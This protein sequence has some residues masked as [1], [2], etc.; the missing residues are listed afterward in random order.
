MNNFIV[1]SSKVKRYAAWFWMIV[2]LFILMN[3]PAP[4]TTSISGYS[5]LDALRELITARWMK[6]AFVI[7]YTAAF[8]WM[9][10]QI[11]AHLPEKHRWLR[12][13][14]W[15]VIITCLCRWLYTW[16]V[17]VPD[18]QSAHFRTYQTIQSL[19]ITLYIVSLLWT[20]Y[21][22]IRNYGG[23]LRLLGWAILAWQLVPTFLPVLLYFLLSQFD[24]ISYLWL[25]EWP[26]AIYTFWRMRQVFIPNWEGNGQLT[27]ENGQ[28]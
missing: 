18:F 25:I 4:R 27:I 17:P 3:I 23:R 16:L 1:S 10:W 20:G 12:W 11:A 5:G 9:I 26:L 21:L 14:L 24:F 28:L 7:A 15:A 13:T 6:Y 8:L 22:L 19:T 2:A